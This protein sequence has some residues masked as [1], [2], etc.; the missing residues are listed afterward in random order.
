[1][2]GLT[3]NTQIAADANASNAK[4]FNVMLIV[5]YSGDTK[6]QLNVRVVGKGSWKYRFIRNFEV[7]KEF[8]T[9]RYGMYKEELGNFFPTARF[10]YMHALN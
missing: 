2:K 6:A 3:Y 7:R 4:I 9:K 1:M 10:N 5:Y 8:P